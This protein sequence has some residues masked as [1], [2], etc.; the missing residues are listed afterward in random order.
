MAAT[1]A[2]FPKN[3]PIQLP[4]MN[5]RK[6]WSLETSVG[7]KQKQIEGRIRLSYPMLFPLC[8]RHQR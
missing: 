1:G 4:D 7:N 2:I 8:H 5:K 3:M 6:K